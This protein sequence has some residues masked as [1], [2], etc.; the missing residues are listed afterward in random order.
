AAGAIVAIALHIALRV[1]EASTFTTL[2]PLYAVLVFGGIPLTYELVVK[3]VQG[4]CG[5]DL[6]AGISIVTSAILG[7]YLAG[8][9]VLLLLA[10]AEALEDSALR[11]ASAVLDA[12]APRTPST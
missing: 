9:L 7:E 4:Q 3:A 1:A 10:G 11:T 5:A 8:S 12:L 2:L 6:L